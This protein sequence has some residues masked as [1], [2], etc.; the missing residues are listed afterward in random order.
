[1][2]LCS[3]EWQ[4]SLQKHAG[5]AFIELVNEG[6]LLAHASKDH[7]VK[8]ANEAE[9]ILN[10]MRADDIRKA[11][12]FEQL[13]AQT[14]VERKGEEQLCEH[15]ITAARQRH[16]A[17]AS[18]LQEKYLAMMI[19]DKTAYLNSSRPFWKLDPWEDDL[20]RRRRLIRN[21]H[22]TIHSEATQ[23]S[24]F[25]GTNDDLITGVIQEENLLKQLKQQKVQNF[26]QT[27]IDEEDMLQIDEKD[28]DHDFS[29]PIRF[30][31][32]C[33][34]ICGTAV[35][36]GTLAITHNAMLFDADEYDDS[37]S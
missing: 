6:R 2:L 16:Q 37:F 12:E 35:V 9:F 28:L 21:A 15:F 23:K 17:I 26:N 5:L 4:N 25:N 20:R 34:L 18:R 3:Q 8:V 7:V 14:T 11:S 24:S 13:S 29:G 31:T 30:S 1:M 36:R 19:N 33:S 32:D 22:G 10:R 27:T